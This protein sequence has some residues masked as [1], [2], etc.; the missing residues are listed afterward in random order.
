MFFDF[1]RFAKIAANVYRPENLYSLDECLHVFSLYF[2]TYEQYIGEPHPPLRASQID[3]IMQDM[4]F[5]SRYNPELL[6]W[7]RENINPN[8]APDIDHDMYPLLIQLHFKTKYRHCD[9]NINHF[10]SG[11]IRKMRL[12]EANAAP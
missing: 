7:L 11:E 8:P 2:K 9:Y 1:Q 5:L 4:P 3:R 6:K 10:F 12:Y